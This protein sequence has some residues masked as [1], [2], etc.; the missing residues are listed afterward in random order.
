MKAKVIENM[1]IGCGACA[2][3]VPEE[4][5]INDEGIAYNLNSTVK[6]FDKLKK[7]IKSKKK[8]TSENNV[9]SEE[10][11]EDSTIEKHE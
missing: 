11:V 3:L 1:C 5:D 4:F 9:I 7:K 2:A 10:K 8:E 6:Y